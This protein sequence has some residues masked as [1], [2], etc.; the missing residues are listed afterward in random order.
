MKFDEYVDA[1]RWLNPAESDLVNFPGFSMDQSVKSACDN[2]L[3]GIKGFNTYKITLNNASISLE[4]KLERGQ[5]LIFIN[6]VSC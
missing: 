2:L 6:S 4:P 1:V 5:C 3:K